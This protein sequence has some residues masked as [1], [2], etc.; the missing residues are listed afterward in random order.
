MSQE[1]RTYWLVDGARVESYS[2]MKKM[3]ESGKTAIEISD[4]QQ[5]IEDQKRK[6]RARANALKDEEIRKAAAQRTHEQSPE[7][8]QE[9]ARRTALEHPGGIVSGGLNP[10]VELDAFG[11]DKT[12]PFR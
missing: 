3:I 6:A 1:F 10:L 11:P 5:R 12:N 4:V 8:Q 9:A 7:G 2:T